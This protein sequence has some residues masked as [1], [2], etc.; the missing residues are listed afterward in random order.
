MTFQKSYTFFKYA[1]AFWAFAMMSFF[2]QLHAVAVLG[3]FL[4]LV[5][6][7]YRGRLR[8]RIPGAVWL[9]L[10]LLGLGL[11]LYGWF[12][13]HE[14]LYSVVYLFLYLEINKLWTGT[15]TR[16]T[17]Q[18]YG[19]TFFQ[20]LAASVST[21]SVLF[22]PA[23][24]IYLFLMLGGMITITMKR[25]AELALGA[26][27]PRRRFFG[28]RPRTSNSVRVRE[29]D[30]R[31]LARIYEQRLLTPRFCRWLGVALVFVLIVGSGLFIIIP[32]IQAQKFIEGVGSTRA[33]Q[34]VSGF[35]DTIDFMGVEDIQTDPTI[36][37]R[38][39]LISGYDMVDGY[40]ERELLRLRGT[41]LD[42][43]DGRRWQKS[44]SKSG[45]FQTRMRRRNI[46]LPRLEAD[47]IGNG[48]YETQITLEPN[49][50]GYLFGPD[51]PVAYDLETPL[52][53]LVDPE[54]QSVRLLLRNWTVPIR[55]RVTSVDVPESSWEIPKPN[56]EVKVD[57]NREALRFATNV[58]SLLLPPRRTEFENI[59]LQLPDHPD[60]QT[61]RALADAW[62]TGL[63]D[64]AQ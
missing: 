47:R 64:K 4:A 37:M 38:A 59:Y 63:T 17:L 41:A 62:T 57:M 51:R 44:E 21:A 16:D 31:R 12:V 20:M 13:V 23:M 32:R 19:L 14:K 50:R 8:L 46:Y 60:T 40:P 33:T 49:R 61:V 24:I 55:Y 29:H 39:K 30:T 1:T 48:E 42:Y 27:P 52:D 7:L 6:C 22:A 45:R 18:V 15:R 9:M 58:I 56:G 35:S 28:G 11:A 5:L 10:S 43:Y 53:S 34:A 2:V 25:D 3:F 26:A 54:A 36:I